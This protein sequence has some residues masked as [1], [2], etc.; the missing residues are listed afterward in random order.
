MAG[1]AAAA[2]VLA[3][4]ETVAGDYTVA[5]VGILLAAVAGLRAAGVSL[6]GSTLEQRRLD[7]CP[8]CGKRDLA[9]DLDGSGIRHCWACG[10]DV[11]PTGITNSS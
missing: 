8:R 7:I 2:V 3:V 4:A 1:F 11:T 9:P 10:A 6:T 5:L